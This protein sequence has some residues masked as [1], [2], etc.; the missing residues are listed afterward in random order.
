MNDQ[1]IRMYAKKLQIK[2]F[3][4]VFMRNALP[5]PSQARPKECAI[6]NLDDFDGPGTHWIAYWKNGNVIHYFDSY[7][8][9]PPPSE[10]L[11]YLGSN[12]KILYNYNQYQEYGSIICGHL[13]LIFLH[14]LSKEEE[15]EK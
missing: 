12:S 11:S 6:I 2:N 5:M 8:N 10:L 7:G 13:C 9:L 3:R 15:E 4:G 1:D 14:Q